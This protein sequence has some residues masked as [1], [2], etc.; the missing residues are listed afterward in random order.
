MTQIILVWG[1]ILLHSG[2]FFLTIRRKALLENIKGIYDYMF[3]KFYSVSDDGDIKVR[4]I[5]GREFVKLKDCE[6]TFK[7]YKYLSHFVGEL[8]FQMPRFRPSRIGHLI[9]YSDYQNFKSLLANTIKNLD[10]KSLKSATG[11]LR[12]HQ[13]RIAEFANDI[14]NLLKENHFNIFM[15]GGTLLGAVRH[16]GFIPWDDD[17]D[18]ALMRPEYEKAVSF[19]RSRYYYLETGDL[20]NFQDYFER[21]DQALKAHPNQIICFKSYQAFKI[22]KGTSLQDYVSVDLFAYDYVNDKITEQEFNDYAD[23][24][25]KVVKESNKWNEIFKFQE[26]ERLKKQVFVSCS[27]KISCGIDNYGFLHYKFRGFRHKADFFPLKNLKFE[28]Y[29]WPTPNNP[30]NNLRKHYGEDYLKLPPDA[31]IPKH[32]IPFL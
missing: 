23:F 30:D 3:K 28:N 2:P 7:Q 24:V 5:F 21:I 20:T 31:G 14:I 11:A 32:N 10:S 4:T 12:A 8:P 19:L 16:Q 17:I 13:L 15:D 18:L 6:K 9:K 22:Y 1:R 29:S 27:D 26:M 25:K